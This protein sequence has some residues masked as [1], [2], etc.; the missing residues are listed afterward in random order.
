MNRIGGYL[1]ASARSGSNAELFGRIAITSGDAATNGR[2]SVGFVNIPVT[3]G[4]RAALNKKVR[5]ATGKDSNS[6]YIGVEE[7][8]GGATYSVWL[9]IR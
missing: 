9:A 1:D 5:G 8:G 6:L 4:V 2:P 7:T 3:D